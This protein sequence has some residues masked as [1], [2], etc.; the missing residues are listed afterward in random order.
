VR[1]TAV[2]LGVWRFSKT[3]Q[4]IV[5]PIRKIGMSVVFRNLTTGL[6]PRRID[7]WLP[8]SSAVNAEVRSPVPKRMSL[9]QIKL[10]RAWHRKAPD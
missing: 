5:Q 4:K 9:I 10:K 1:Y 2:N 7:K 6:F 3:T 8:A